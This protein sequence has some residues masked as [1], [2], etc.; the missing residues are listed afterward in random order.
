MN[1][2]SA[3]LG[4]PVGGDLQRPH[5]P[6]ADPDRAEGSRLPPRRAP[7]PCCAATCSIWGLGGVIVPFIGIKLIDLVLVDTASGQLRP[8]TRTPAHRIARRIDAGAFACDLWLLF[9]TCSSFACVYPLAVLGIAELVFPY[10]AEGS[11]VDEKGR[12]VTDAEKAVGSRLIAQPFTAEEYFQPRPSA[13]SYNATASGAS[14]W[15]ANNY[16]LRDRVARQ[17]GPIVKYRGGREKGQL[18]APAI[19]EL[20]PTGPVRGPSGHCVPVGRGPSHPGPELGQ[21]GQGS[22]RVRGGLAKGPPG[23]VAHGP[24]TTRTTPNPSPKTWP[25]R[26][27]RTTPPPLRARFPARSSTRRR[28]ARRKRRSSRSKR[29]ATSSRSSSTCGGKTILT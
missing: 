9:L 3:D 23:R 26:F 18:V 24:R 13:V 28:T 7:T 14:N 6:P 21:G 1:L 16:L 20:V 17:L 8:W 15:G 4:D 29:G 5:H 11:L 2:H 10:Q 19:E 27:S 25:S 22:R 12:P